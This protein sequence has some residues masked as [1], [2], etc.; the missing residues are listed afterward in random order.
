MLNYNIFEFMQ[1]NTAT[2]I[3]ILILDISILFCI[4][5]SIFASL[6]LKLYDVLEKRVYLWKNKTTAD[7]YQFTS[8]DNCANYD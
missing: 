4:K 7:K 5:I 3:L 2:Q 8:K 1:N 6:Y